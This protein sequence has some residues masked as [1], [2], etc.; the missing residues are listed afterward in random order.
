MCEQLRQDDTSEAEY[1]YY[2]HT[3]EAFDKWLYENYMIWNGNR[4]VE[5]YEDGTVRDKYIKDM[6]LPIDTE[7]EFI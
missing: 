7:L 3:Q 1:Y 2:M 4:L 6:G 5:L